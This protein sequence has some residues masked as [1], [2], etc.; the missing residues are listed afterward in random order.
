MDPEQRSVEEIDDYTKEVTE[1]V[2]T[3][4]QSR[5]DKQ[6]KLND[7]DLRERNVLKYVLLILG[8]GGLLIGTVASSAITAVILQNR[9]ST[10]IIYKSII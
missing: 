3:F 8:V 10:S 7:D 4:D 9:N 1:G 5:V 6:C 2:Y